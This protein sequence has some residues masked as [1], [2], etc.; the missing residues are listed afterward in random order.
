MSR[1]LLLLLTLGFSSVGLAQPPARD[2]SAVPTGT[3]VVRGRVVAAGSDRPLG[4]AEVRVASGLMRVNK[5]VLTDAEGMYEVTD[6]PAGR[7][8]VTAVKPNYVR[9]GWGQRRLLGP[10]EPIE[11]AN[12]Q[13]QQ[14]INFALQRTGAITGRIVDE[15][16]DPATDVQVMPMR[17]AFVNGERRLQPA[18]LPAS[19]DD[20]GEFRLFGLMPGQYII[21]ATLRTFDFGADTN[22][23]AGYAPTFYPGTGNAADAQW[24]TLAPAQ[25]I[26]DMNLTLLPVM[27]VRVSGTALDAQGR[28]MVGAYVGLVPRTGMMFRPGPQSGPVRRDGSFVINGAV[29]G[30]YT[31][32]VNLPGVRDE[33]AAVD[34]TVGSSD[35][36]DV[37][38]VAAKLSIIRG[39]V[40]FEPGTAKLPSPTAVRVFI[41]AGTSVAFGD[42]TTV[43]NDGTFELKG[44]AGHVQL[45]ANVFGNGDWRLKRAVVGDVDVTDSGIDVAPNAT[46]ENLV[47]EMTSQLPELAVSVTDAAGSPVHDCVVV[48]FGRDDRRWTPPSRYV[49]VG[50]PNAVESI[51]QVRVPPGD[52]LA[53]AFEDTEQDLGIFADPEILAQLRDR[54]TPFSIGDGEKKDLDVKLGQPPVY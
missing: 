39:R 20:L 40:V 51:F 42:N 13:V 14:G 48:L 10:P 35:L 3:A 33:Y 34:V 5:V 37:Q 6:L 29:P 53:A 25:T 2:T 28:P 8:T 45:R 17:Y 12:G 11:L 4:R 41:T 24:I 19:T 30:D 44:G 49:A 26:A 31:V 21:S 22:D 9:A 43:K 18:G 16:G 46:I 52:Y 15:F 50:R 36:T 47:V 54:A 7:F 32:R 23:R 1:V 27:T 38:L